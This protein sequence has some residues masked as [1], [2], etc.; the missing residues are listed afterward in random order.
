MQSVEIGDAV[1]AEHH[2]LAI[3]DELPLPVLQRSL[4]DPG[5]ALSPIKTVP[6]K[7]ARPI[8]VAMDDHAIAVELDLVKPARPAGNLGSAR[9]EAGSNGGFGMSQR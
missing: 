1:D 9:R 8:A 2:G 5:I 6:G 7:Q 4:D 3:N